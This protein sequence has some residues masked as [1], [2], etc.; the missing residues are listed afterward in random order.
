VANF[1]RV[2]TGYAHTEFSWDDKRIIQSVS[3]EAPGG[4]MNTERAMR[5]TSGGFCDSHKED[6]PKSSP[7]RRPTPEAGQQKVCR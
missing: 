3:L 1:T 7:G 6:C 2:T 5:P 4:R